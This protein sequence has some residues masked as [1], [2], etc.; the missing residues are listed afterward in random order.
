MAEWFVEEGIGETR[1]V[2]LEGG[3]I[4]EARVAWPGEL[5]AGTVAGARLVS[6]V[7]GAS[8]GVAE[9]ADGT[10]ALV[11]RLP[12]DASEGAAIRLLVTRPALAERGRTKPVRGQWSEAALHCAPTL[13]EKL[14]SEGHAVRIVR[15]FPDGD[16][17]GLLAEAFTGEIAFPG[18]TLALSPTP[19]M[20]LIDVD[21]EAEPRRLALAAC[22]AIAAA[23]GRFD[24]GGSIGIDFPTLADK[25]ARRA[26]D[27]ALAC[28]LALWP[29]GR[30]AMNGFGFVQIVARLERPSLLYRAAFHPAAT[31]ARGLLR[32][33]ETLEGAGGVAL[34]ANPSLG[35]H[36]GTE[37][38]A[39]LAR[40]TGREVQIRLDPGLAVSAPQ[41][42]FV[43]R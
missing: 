2:H 11:E 20:T 24:L 27:A 31:A 10:R 36:L 6:R 26:V 1:A 17:D 39:E 28:A 18:G 22:P 12:G 4:A 41:A 16:W 21:G 29:H 34:A 42:Q 8:R 14:E 15:R 13:A 43:E 32:R 35:A 5:A 40:K 38:L 33:A 9:L 23:L 37:R 3:E 19:A 7:R 25:A 30:T